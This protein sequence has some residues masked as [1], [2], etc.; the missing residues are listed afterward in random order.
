M[1]QI[2]VNFAQIPENM[3]S[4]VILKYFDLIRLEITFYWHELIQKRNH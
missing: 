2:D 4:T 3:H 1:S